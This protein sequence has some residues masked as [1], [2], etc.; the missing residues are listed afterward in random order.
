MGKDAV[1]FMNRLYVNAWTNLAVGRCRYGV[2]LRDDGFIYDDGVVARISEDRFHVTTTTGGAPRVLALMEDYLQT[3]WSEL[4]VWLT[5]T[6]EQWAVI[7][8]QGPR[9]REVL[10]G[11]V[12]VDI[13]ASALPAHERRPRAHLR[14]ADAAV[15]RE[16]HRGAGL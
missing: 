3:E 10:A 6:T 14:C 8:V 7:A 4:K 9:A 2:L 5:S 16:L 1:T 13:S 12:D 15:S 11:L